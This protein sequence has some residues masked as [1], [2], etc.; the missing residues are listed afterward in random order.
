MYKKSDILTKL[1]FLCPLLFITILCVPFKSSGQKA[2]AIRSI[3]FDELHE[4]YFVDSVW[5]FHSGDLKG[6]STDT[7]V[8]TWTKFRNTS[9]GKSDPPPG[10][11]GLGWFAVWVRA[12][13][14]LVNQELALRI[15]HDGASEI[16]IDGKPIGGYGK[17]GNSKENM[18]AIRPPRELIPVWFADTIPHLIIIRYSNFDSTYPDF[19]GF[20]LSIG[21]Y[22]L[23]AKRMRNYNDLLNAVP[24]F[25]AAQ[26]ILALLHFFFFL[27]Y[28]E[29]KLNLN[30]AVFVLLIGINGA[31]IYFFYQARAPEV[32]HFAEWLTDECK[33]LIMWAGVIL[34]YSLSYIKIPAWRKWTLAIISLGYFSAYFIR[35]FY[36]PS[37]PWH[38]FFSLIFF[39]CIIDGFWAVYKVIR[40]Q[41]KG[42]WLVA[43]GLM[44]VILLYFFAWDDIFGLWP[45]RLNAVRI[46]VLSAGELMLP[47]CLSLYLA[48]DFA[49]TNQSLTSRLAEL[50]TMSAL[51]LAQE[52]EKREMIAGEAKRLEQLVDLRTAELRNNTEKLKELDAV[53]SRF[54]TNITHEFKT[55]LTLIINPAKALIKT[56]AD[57]ENLQYLQLILKNSERLLGLINQLLDLSKLENGL[58]EI[59]LAPVNLVS[60]IKSHILSYK[61]VALQKESSLN[62]LADVEELWILGDQAKLDTIVLNL[63]S[64]AVKFTEKGKIDM[65]L[66]MS[67][68]KSGSHFLLTVRDSGS[69]IPAGKLPYIF[70]R[71][72]QADPSDTRSAE[73]TGIGLALTKELVEL[74]D[75]EITV[76]SAEG[77][78]TEVIV[79]IPYEPAAANYQVSEV[80]DEENLPAPEVENPDLDIEDREKPL[81]L[82]IEDHEELRN[83]MRQLLTERYNVLT[84]TDGNEGIELGMTNIPEL[85]ITDLMMPKANGYEVSSALKNDEKTSH[86][87]IIMLTAK[88]DTDSRVKGIEAGVD[89]YISKPFD[90]RELFAQI[91]NLMST[92]AQL[93]QLYSRS[94]W[95]NGLSPMPPQ[96]KDFITRVREAIEG[97]LNEEGYS[98]D[99]LARDM[100]LSRAQ[101]HRK[102]KGVVG[103]SPGELIRTVRLQYAHNLLL[104]QTMTVAE[105]AYLVG[106]SSPASFSV[107]FSR[108]FGFPPKK[109]GEP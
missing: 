80:L 109:A 106:F 40:K 30:Y 92:R 73:G 78:Y 77:L 100:G 83:F 87:P 94:L 95:T 36:F 71:F 96:E 65:Y 41:Q 53:K 79:T 52:T 99:Q 11:N 1:V 61:S 8:S 5:Y 88:G 58:M 49:R 33:V 43:I 22:D 45:Y 32:Q 103:Q 37:S 69:G 55:P 34:L 105:V 57:D 38:D 64:N 19:Y 20:Q 15:N 60:V 39:L 42:V 56:V 90:E 97:H 26:L 47:I 85:V 23:L 12:D 89:A 16:Y 59:N 28:P 21:D 70:E 13:R 6:H 18:E 102:L 101:L 27:F 74:L 9:F 107:S 44:A 63:L 51:A 14:G 76:D 7:A 81:I 93:R 17:V 68:E 67:Q 50:Q 29:R 24:L 62:F 75:G 31:C 108:H 84:A 3:N 48:L 72:Y 82:L 35:Q 91:D 54:F 2:T 4:M 86:I 25:A 46:F 10:W 98:A 66:E 104:Q